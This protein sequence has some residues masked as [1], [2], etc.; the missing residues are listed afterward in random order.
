[1]DPEA[2]LA[3]AAEVA[4]QRSAKRMRQTVRDMAL[5]MLAVG[6]LVLLIAWPGRHDASSQIRTVDP[7]PATA[8][9]ATTVS[10][11]VLSPAGLPVQWRCTSV[12]I[13]SMVDATSGL[14]QG[15][16]TP[17]EQ[18]VALEQSD[19]R[20][21]G[22]LR[23][24]TSDGQPAGT[25]IIAGATWE[26]RESVSGAQ[27]SLVRIVGGVTYVVGGSAQWSEI[28]TFTAALRPVA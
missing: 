25:L 16:V 12:R 11:P 8:A 23:R 6:A 3:A 1:M 4:A 22:Y 10:W 2:E 26:R 9:F 7:V 27:R 20:D 28:E 17:A 15:W 21:V 14:H 19:T 5:S 18:Y 13:E 24:S